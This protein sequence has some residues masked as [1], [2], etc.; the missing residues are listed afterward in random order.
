[1]YQVNDIGGVAVAKTNNETCLS[2]S[3]LVLK[4]MLRRE[5]Y[6]HLRVKTCLKVGM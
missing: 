5:S 1:M 3:C 6:M 4:M 2:S